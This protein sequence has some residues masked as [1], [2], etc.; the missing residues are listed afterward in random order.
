MTCVAE[1]EICDNCE[2]EIELLEATEMEEDEISEMDRDHGITEQ[3]CMGC[4][5][6][7]RN[8][9]EEF[10]GDHSPLHPE[11]TATDFAEHEDLHSK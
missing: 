4:R 3:T 8:D 11:E 5:K 1:P 10:R 9:L 6:E 7:T 2:K